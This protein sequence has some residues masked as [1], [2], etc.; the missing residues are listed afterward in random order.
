MNSNK[1]RSKLYSLLEQGTS[2]L[3]YWQAY[4]QL[5]PYLFLE[6]DFISE[7]SYRQLH[8]QSSSELQK[9]GE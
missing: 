1:L 3:L 5:E 2:S 9:Y 6:L 7:Q 4:R 8:Q